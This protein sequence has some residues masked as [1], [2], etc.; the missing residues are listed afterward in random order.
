MDS[1]C[2]GINDDRIAEMDVIKL[3]RTNDDVASPQL[4]L[5][6]LFPGV[7]YQFNDLTEQLQMVH[8]LSF[9]HYGTSG[10]S[11]AKG[12]CKRHATKKWWILPVF[13]GG[14]GF[15]VETRG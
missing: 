6:L 11:L 13:E 14:G 10:E 15:V 3:F 12:I 4:D 2:V 9:A 1:D 8:S 7:V 5:C